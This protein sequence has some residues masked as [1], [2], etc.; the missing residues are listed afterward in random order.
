MKTYLAISIVVVTAVFNL[1]VAAQQTSFVEL[2]LSNFD[3]NGNHLNPTSDRQ[4]IMDTLK[5]L[6]NSSGGDV[7][8]AADEDL[9]KKISEKTFVEALSEFL[10]EVEDSKSMDYTDV[11]SIFHGIEGISTLLAM[12]KFVLEEP[13][14]MSG[15]IIDYGFAKK[16]DESGNGH[17]G[18]QMRL[19]YFD[20]NGVLYKQKFMHWDVEAINYTVMKRESTE[21]ASY[22]HNP[23]P[24]A[25][26]TFPPEGINPSD[27]RSVWARG[28]DHKLFAKGVGNFKIHDVYLMTK[29]VASTSEWERLPDTDYRYQVTESSCIDLMF[30]GFPPAI[31][32]PPQVGYCLGRCDHPR[33]INSR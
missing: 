32:L 31:E 23:Y 22:P 15:K 12:W 25:P 5:E 10:K 14:T 27:L 16:N 17:L 7:P 18:V 1:T 4:A 9:K 11:P 20:K 6:I 30:A 29:T 33:I 21:G 3:Q 2:G 24:S 8:N 28:L 26:V 13:V 19:D